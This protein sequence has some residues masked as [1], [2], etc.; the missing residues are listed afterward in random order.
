[1]SRPSLRCRLSL[2]ALLVGLLALSP[3][4][5]AKKKRAQPAARQSE[6]RVVTVDES[7]DAEAVKEALREALREAKARGAAR[8]VVRRPELVGPLPLRE[9]GAR[10]PEAA[11]FP[12]RAARSGSEPAAGP[13]AYRPVDVLAT[14]PFFE[15]FPASFHAEPS[16]AAQGDAVVCVF[17]DGGSDP[18]SPNPSF[19]SSTDGF[20]ISTDGGATFQDQGKRA[21]WT[22]FTSFNGDNVVAAG[23]DGDFYYL[24]DGGKGNEPWSAMAASRSTD[25]GRS[26]SVPTSPSQGRTPRPP[27]GFFDKGWID[28]DR[29]SG[30]TRGRVYVTWSDFSFTLGTTDLWFA[31]SSDRGATW[32]SQKLDTF[33]HPVSVTYVQVAPNGWV[34]VGEQDEGT[35]VDG[36]FTGTNY[37]RVSTDGGVTFSALRSAG[38]YAAVG[39][40]KAIAL[41]GDPGFFGGLVRYLNGPIE[42]D[43]SLR[44]AVDPSDATGKTVFVSTQAVPDDKPGDESD[45]YVWK[46][47][48]AGLTWSPPRRVNDDA[49]TADQFMPDLWIAPDGTL[50]VLWLDRRND[51]SGNFTLEAWMA[52]SRD[53]GETWS[54]NFPVSSRPFPP[55][56]RCQM[57]D[58]NGVFADERR[59]HLAWGD[60]RQIDAQAQA[61][62]AISTATLPLAGPGPILSL[63]RVEPV[64]GAAAGRLGV[65]IRLRNDGLEAATALDARLELASGGASTSTPF[66][67]VPACHGASELEI[68]IELPTANPAGFEKATL[69]VTGP[70]GAAAFPLSIPR[71]Q[72]TPVGALL[73]TD[74]ESPTPEWTPQA[75]SLWQITDQCAARDPGHSGSRVAYFGR[76]GACD[77]N[78][79]TPSG[80]ARVYGALTSRPIAIPPGVTRLKFK[81]WMGLQGRWRSD[82]AALQISTDA[83]AS[84]ENLWGWGRMSR[85]TDDSIVLTGPNG[86]PT[87]HD[88]DLDLSGYAGRVVLLRFFFN[89]VGKASPGYAVDDV[90]VVTVSNLPFGNLGTCESPQIVDL[91]SAPSADVRASFALAASVSGSPTPPCGSAPPGR[92]FWFRFTPPVS[93]LYELSTCASGA[94]ATLSVWKGSCGAKEPVAG[95]CAAASPC[96]LPVLPPVVSVRGEAGVPLDVLVSTDDP[97]ASSTFSL[98][99]AA[100][101][102]AEVV[103]VVLDVPAASTRFTTELALTNRSG[104]AATATLRYT[105][106]LGTREGAGSVTE[107]VPPRGQLVF[108]DVLA[109]L[110][111]RGLP[112]PASGA[113]GGTLAV[114]FDRG[115]APLVAATARTS[116]AV[117][118]PHPAG[119]ASLAYA[120]VPTDRD[121]PALGVFGLR[122]DGNDRSKLAV[123]STSAEPVAL[124]VSVFS[125]ADGR[126][127]VYREA[128]SLGPFAWLQYEDVLQAAGF[129]NG[130]AVVER[131][132]GTGSFS[133]YGVVNDNATDD[134][135]FLFPVAG[136]FAGGG[137]TVPV[138]VETPRFSTELVLANRGA[139]AATLTLRYRESLDRS[140]GAGGAATV[141][142]APGEQRIVK[143][144]AAFLRANGVAIGAKGGSYAG[145]LRV[146]VAGAI[147]SDV[148]AA[149][150]VAAPSVGGGAFG[151]FAPP[152]YRGEEAGAEPVSLVGLKADETS[153]TNVAFVNAGEDGAGSIRL[154]AT[155]Y[156]AEAD[157][158]VRGTLEVGLD[159]G[160]WFQPL[161]WFGSTG[162]RNGWVTVT[163]VEGS[164]PWLAY[165]VVNDGRGPGQR[166]DDG[167]FVPMR[168]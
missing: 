45:V 134:G 12:A 80:A 42:A 56:G 36:R 130:Y 136:S 76:L 21:P 57:S 159:A 63:D 123:F 112:I 82:Y 105:P 115:S 131:V 6:P 91:S 68:P 153:R 162:I 14:N 81:E 8:V 84:F 93:G 61:T 79:T 44:I 65:R 142:L 59:F 108:P 49:T 141:V 27:D 163:R 97:A 32:T 24:S 107:T 77:Y 154:V 9:P 111:S 53:R 88:V 128:E 58:Y 132:G 30:P 119:D 41:C 33:P 143:D 167:A 10:G 95:A 43:S 94:A 98:R 38:P 69:T 18:T 2:A 25:G 26:W 109:R 145:A 15:P 34:Y 62:F 40:A 90:R 146:D 110:R 164:A 64:L 96:E 117:G 166:T 158:A 37:L 160:A 78:V 7:D 148:Y 144:A 5:E 121:A 87:W 101:A 126:R 122:T 19:I 92:A 102:A 161:N 138:V 48:D 20:S 71:P 23:P 35:V 125:G 127:V 50:G 55:I 139:R 104:A 155:A 129:A 157:G 137:L 17:N 11:G 31:R 4:A 135:S 46:S 72:A 16:I 60:G 47:T 150:R 89:G 124:R 149:A 75:G 28:V 22:G 133:A 73:S 66:P 114:A 113:N 152:V 165:A 3:A 168:R 39:N 118:A 99:V 13:P 147:L 29:S 103:P 52:I 100:A 106:S 156:D 1:M 85:F 140:G 51:P 54:C 83:G 116:A 151:L 74:F 67:D 86:R 120:G 70:R